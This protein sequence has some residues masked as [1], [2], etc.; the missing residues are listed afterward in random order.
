MRG[1]SRLALPN[2][3]AYAYLFVYLVYLCL[4]LIYSR[5][6]SLKEL[7]YNNSY[8]Q[9]PPNPTFKYSHISTVLPQTAEARER[10][11][12]HGRSEPAGGKRPG[13]GAGSD[14]AV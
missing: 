5:L 3:Y 2:Q 1:L 13:G 12:H 6:Y 8:P 14:G 4:T 10:S 11:G 9:I 7:V